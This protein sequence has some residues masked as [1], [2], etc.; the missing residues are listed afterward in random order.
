M[1][2]T[3]IDIH[4]VDDDIFEGNENFTVAIVG[5]MLPSGVSRGK[6]PVATIT[7]MDIGEFFV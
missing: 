1:T 6:I 5:G 4:I 7:I 2:L 3:S